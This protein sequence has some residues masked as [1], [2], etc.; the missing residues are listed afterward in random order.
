MIA[1]AV[2]EVVP[3]PPRVEEVHLLLVIA[4]E[5]AQARVV[6]QQPPV[7]VDDVEAGRAI[8]E[9]LAELA[10]VLGDLGRALPVAGARLLV[11]HRGDGPVIGHRDLHRLAAPAAR[12]PAR[13][14]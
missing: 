10:L 5:L 9:D 3:E 12:A 13:Q 1:G 14:R 11:Q 7:L 8:F 2:V 6:E 4:H